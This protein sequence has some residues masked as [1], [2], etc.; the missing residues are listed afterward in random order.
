MSKIRLFFFSVFRAAMICIIMIM[1][2]TTSFLAKRHPAHFAVWSIGTEV[3]GFFMGVATTTVKSPN[4]I[5]S[6]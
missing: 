3:S 6:F 1:K 4:G 5:T 2:V